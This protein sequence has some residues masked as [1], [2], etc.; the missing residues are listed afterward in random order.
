MRHTKR[1]EGVI[2]QP[3]WRQSN[4]RK[5]RF[6]KWKGLAGREV[7][8]HFVRKVCSVITVCLALYTCASNDSGIRALSS[9]PAR[10]ARTRSD[11][12]CLP[13]R[14][15]ACSHAYLRIFC[16]GHAPQVLSARTRK[17]RVEHTVQLKSSFIHVVWRKF[18]H[19]VTV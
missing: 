6:T 3:E 16:R 12:T 2:G 9:E 18:A 13:E 17:H 8:K 10:A 4:R 11:R 7:G 14:S 1:R 15:R 5:I 19:H